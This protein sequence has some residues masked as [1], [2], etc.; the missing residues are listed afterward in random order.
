MM[1]SDG[2]VFNKICLETGLKPNIPT[3][4]AAILEDIKRFHLFNLPAVAFSVPDFDETI[5][6]YL[7]YPIF[8]VAPLRRVAKESKQIFPSTADSIRLLDA[9]ADGDN[10]L[11]TNLEDR[12]MK[13]A[14]FFSRQEFMETVIAWAFIYFYL[15]TRRA[16][17]CFTAISFLLPSKTLLSYVNRFEHLL[18]ENAFSSGKSK[19]SYLASIVGFERTSPS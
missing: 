16:H 11:Y 5:A 12:L 10:V 7:P 18:E 6:A 15:K 1:K 8:K 4:D 3:L 14:R 9:Y 13:A 17:R 2:K 19:A